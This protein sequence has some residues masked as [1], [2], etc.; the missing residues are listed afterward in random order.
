[1]RVAYARHRENRTAWAQ[2]WRHH[3]GPRPTLAVIHGFGAS[4][5]WLNSQFFALPSIYRRGY[6]VLL[7][8]LP[9][10]GVRQARVALSGWGLFANGIAH[11]IEAIAHAVHDSGCTWT[12]SWG[13]ASPPSPSPASRSAGGSRRSSRPSM[14]DSPW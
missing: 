1:M 6:D 2:H 9:F 14:I 11:F 5:Y 3:D 13:R 8:L 7:Y 10:H 4:P 12:T